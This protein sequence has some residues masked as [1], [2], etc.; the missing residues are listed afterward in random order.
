PLLIPQKKYFQYATRWFY[1]GSCSVPLKQPNFLCSN[2][3]GPRPQRARSR[4]GSPRWPPRSA[5]T[6]SNPNGSE[7]H[8]STEA[9]SVC[10]FPRNGDLEYAVA[11]PEKP[12]KFASAPTTVARFFSPAGSQWALNFLHSLS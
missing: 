7:H 4:D 3:S 6:R 1:C 10:L 11:Q 9:G 12:P 5:K 2:P 8:R